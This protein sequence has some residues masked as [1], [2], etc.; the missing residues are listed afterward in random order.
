L[1]LIGRIPDTLERIRNANGVTQEEDALLLLERAGFIHFAMIVFTTNTTADGMAHNHG[2]NYVLLASRSL[3]RR[4]AALF[5]SQ[6]ATK[7]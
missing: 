7:D 6:K 2:R 3:L 1:F 4:Y 5:L